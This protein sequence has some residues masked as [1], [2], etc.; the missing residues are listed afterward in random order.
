MRISRAVTVLSA[1]LLA[2]GLVL[3]GAGSA[4]A[5][6]V[7]GSCDL[8]AD[9]V[10]CPRAVLDGQ[11]L[12]RYDLTGAN[13]RNALMNAVVNDRGMMASADLYAV[14]FVKAQ[15]RRVDLS[16]ANLR[17]VNLSIADLTGANLTRANLTGAEMPG[18]D[19]SGANL[20]GANL[21]RAFVGDG[22]LSRVNLTGANLTRANLTGANLAG[23]NLAGVRWTGVICPNGIECPYPCT[24]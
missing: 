14:N 9:P 13:L 1:V 19:L 21:T 18:V 12:R 8:T 20:S 3:V 24:S 7:A 16:G 2:T 4:S 17:N 10:S 23:A 11:D 6:D 15:M 5:G 22:N